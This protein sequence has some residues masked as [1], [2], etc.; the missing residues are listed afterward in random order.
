MQ[1]FSGESVHY[2]KGNRSIGV[3][4]LLFISMIVA[5]TA[6]SEFQDRQ[7]PTAA[8]QTKTT[9]IHTI[10]PQASSLPVSEPVTPQVSTIDIPAEDLRGVLLRFWHPWSGATQKAV[11]GLVEQ[12]NLSNPWGILVAEVPFSGYDSLNTA[13]LDSESQF[14]TP[15]VAAGFLHQ[16]LNWDQSH[17]LMDLN[18]YAID[19]EWGLSQH[20][21]EDFYPLFW[22]YDKVDNRRLGI[23]TYR[24]AQLLIYNQSWAE[25]LGFSTPP[26]TP[27][28]FRQQTCAAAES[29]LN[30]DFPEN[31]GMG[32]WIISTEPAVTLSWIRAFSGH[33][34]RSPIP[35]HD[36][37]IYQFN[38]SSAQRSF[39][40]LRDLFDRGCAWIPQASAPDLAFASRQGLI[41]TASLN[42]LP[43]ISSALEALDNPDRWT[44][45]PF[46]SE[47]QSPLINV[48]GPSY[49]ALQAEPD[50]QLAAWLFIR[51]MSLPENNVRIIETNPAFPA[52]IST[53]KYLQPYAKRHP[54]WASA[55]ELLENAQNEP[56]AGSWGAVRR[57]L[58][59]ATTQLYRSYFTVDQ[60]GSLLDYL[61]H[62]SAELHLGTDLKSV[63]ATLTPTP[64]GRPSRTPAPSSSPTL[65]LTLTIHTPTP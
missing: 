40:Y 6:C 36:Q 44:I 5:I 62:F 4:F 21:R 13:L 14:E 15:N 25:E 54:Q 38:T 7:T 16:A 58:G 2:R 17:P 34:L 9:A 42:D 10:A 49:F 64:G 33:V 55:L 24:S 59:D 32:G 12:F 27:E 29:Y 8:S 11:S 50:E 20:E 53:I 1:T 28:E 48:Y 22:E 35:A 65:E 57:S 41:A 56:A 63:F 23:P 43:F 37:S 61:D 3:H 47:T 30:D 60:I 18:I 19:P 46:P 45:L 51:W 31:N 52:R 39:T 26:A